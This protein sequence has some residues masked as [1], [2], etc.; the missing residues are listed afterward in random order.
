MQVD[1]NS[2][3]LIDMGVSGEDDKGGGRGVVN[4]QGGGQDSKER[5][6]AWEALI[7]NVGAVQEG[8]TSHT[9]RK[10]RTHTHTHVRIQELAS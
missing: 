9:S 6:E 3:P 1:T 5:R 8:A 10:V 4:G 2:L 7:N